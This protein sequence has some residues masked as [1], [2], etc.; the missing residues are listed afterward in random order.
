MS[1]FT[2][3]QSVA[4]DTYFNIKTNILW[5]W[6]RVCVRLCVGMHVCVRVEYLNL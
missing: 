5:E 6:V 3:L 1:S 4:G 2:W